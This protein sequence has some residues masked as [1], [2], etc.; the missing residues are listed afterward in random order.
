[1]VE[2]LDTS[3]GRLIA[4]LEES[5]QLDDTVIVFSSDHGGSSEGGGLVAGE[6]TV[7]GL[8]DRNNELENFG[9]PGSFIDHGRGFAEAATAPLRDV[10]GAIGEGGLR[11]A[12]FVHYPAAIAGG[13]VSHEFMTIMDVLP[14]F[15]E[16][17]GSEH[18]GATSYKGREI[19][20][21]T[22][23]RS[24]PISRARP[25]RFMSRQTRPAGPP[26]VVTAH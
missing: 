4:Y 23:A 16:I 25:M 5:G 11:A 19:T 15:L 21:S 20:R 12:A 8:P 26:A 10:K 7:R 18:P 17:A 6:T 1:M 14:T 2:Y 3:V 22:V 9:Q 13:D 24:G